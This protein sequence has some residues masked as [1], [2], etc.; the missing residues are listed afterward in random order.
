VL[1]K[2]Q[3]N[4]SNI[5]G[6][7]GNSHH[8]SNARSCTSSYPSTSKGRRSYR[9]TQLESRFS[10]LHPG[11]LMAFFVSAIVLT[12]LSY[13][14]LILGL[15]F[16][17]AAMSIA[18]YIG[19]KVLA[20]TMLWLVP[21]AAIVVLFN[22]LFNRRGATELLTIEPTIF[23]QQ[24]HYTFTF[25]SL[26]F[27]LSVALMFGAIILWFRLY[28]EYMTSDRFLFLFAPFVPT[29]A[30]SISMAQRWIP[31]TKYRW[32]QIRNAQKALN[33]KSS[34]ESGRKKT[35]VYRSLTRSMSAL[36]SWSMED[37]IQAA[38]SMQARGYSNARRTSFR[39]YRFTVCD[40]VSLIFITTT[41]LFAAV[42]I[43]LSTRGL[44]FFP[45]LRG[46]EDVSIFAL[47]AMAAVLLFPLAL[48]ALFS[49]RE[50]LKCMMHT[51]AQKT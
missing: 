40:T 13:H 33:S 38:D 25:E 19:L 8:S 11:V 16:V 3:N 6:K 35:A 30:L 20:Q 26:L 44:A 39:S 1:L 9:S 21:M 23:G 43:F 31:L 29:I 5:S 27:G 48:S 17:I 18:R 10:L 12:L 41:T 49:G 37:A 46:I 51:S 24:Q 28:Q 32:Q 7:G 34:S 15:S 47:A 22:V 45:V 2:G 4:N 36:M 42:S 14:P 50:Q